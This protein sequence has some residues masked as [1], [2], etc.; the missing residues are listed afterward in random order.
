MTWTPRI[1]S[2]G[3]TPCWPWYL[4]DNSEGA[5]TGAACC[6]CGVD[7]A[8]PVDQRGFEP[9]CL[10][11]A[12]AADLL[13]LIERSPDDARSLHQVMLDHKGAG[14]ANRRGAA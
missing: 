11:C 2:H 9:V 10:Y 13:P 1:V 14:V 8:Q 6:T 3:Q 12:F 7:V 4:R 5:V